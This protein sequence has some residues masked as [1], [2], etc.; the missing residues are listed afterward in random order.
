MCWRVWN[1]VGFGRDSH[2]CSTGLATAVCRQSLARL[3]VLDCYRCHLLPLLLLQVRALLPH[4]A[5]HQ[6]DL[7]PLHSQDGS[8]SGGVAR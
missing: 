8:S 3:R 5:G 4:A 2:V 1:C 6:E 7:W